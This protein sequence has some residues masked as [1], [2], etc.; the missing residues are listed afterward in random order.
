M[1]KVK[2]KNSTYPSVVGEVFFISTENTPLHLKKFLRT[3]KPFA[4]KTP[5]GKKLRKRGFASCDTNCSGYLSLAET[6]SFVLQ[7]LKKEYGQEDG[8]EY[9]KMFRPSYILA[10]NEAK[11]YVKTEDAGDNDDDFVSFPEFRVFNTYLC[12]FAAM[13]D[14]FSLVDGGGQRGF[15]SKNDRRI[16]KSEWLKS[17][18]LL[19]DTGFAS[20]AKIQ[21]DTQATVA[22]HV[23][24]AD[25]QGMVLL[26]EFCGY[27][28]QAEIQK[29]TGLGKL[30]SG[31]EQPISPKKSGLDKASI[32]AN[33]VTNA[34]S[35]GQSCS[36]DLKDFIRVFQ[37]LTEKTSKGKDLR[38]KNFSQVDQNRNGY[39][40]LAEIDSF[41]KSA[42]SKSLLRSRTDFLFNC[43]RKSY[44]KA[45]Q[46]A[47]T[48]CEAGNDQVADDYVTFPEFRLF[49][50]FLCIYAT[51]LDAFHSINKTSET[52]DYHEFMKSYKN[53]RDYGFRALASIQSIKDAT[54]TFKNLDPDGSEKVS[55]NEWC[56]YIINVEIETGTD[57]G[58]IMQMKI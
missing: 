8:E 50:V 31:V 10:F 29:G 52:I 47:K 24:D 9:F 5:D 46:W 38:L 45:F 43:F 40:S 51:L 22:F 3:F 21:N 33:V 1:P 25:K 54:E 23:M 32:R 48:V 37:P 11:N 39:A 16:S 13:Y 4:E 17:Y 36:I 56:T 12:V 44:I 57:L 26:K 19:R 41:I 34:K 20:F 53:S 6:E 55:Y 30:F 2:E 28:K 15:D 49:N 7:Q 42:L 18:M 27:V 14:A 58:K 35:P